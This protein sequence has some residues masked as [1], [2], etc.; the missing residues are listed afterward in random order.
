MPY[1]ETKNGV[2]LY[3]GKIKVHVAIASGSLTIT[4]PVPGADEVISESGQYTLDVVRGE[5]NFTVNGSVTYN[6]W[7]E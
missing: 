1:S 6:Y 3:P 7:D 2:Q 4:G 5:Y